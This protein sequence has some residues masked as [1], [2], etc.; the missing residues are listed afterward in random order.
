VTY[1]SHFP[2]QVPTIIAIS[3]STLN[4]PETDWYEAPNVRHLALDLLDGEKVAEQI[5]SHMHLFSQVTHLFHMSYI[6]SD[7]DQ[8]MIDQNMAMLKN[9]VENLEKVSQL[10]H[11]SLVDGKIL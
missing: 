2:K 5:E 1:L 7:S 11:V 3:R 4:T 6:E 9:I 8:E 10:K